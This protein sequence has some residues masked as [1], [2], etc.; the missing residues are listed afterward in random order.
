MVSVYCHN[1]THI[2]VLWNGRIGLQEHAAEAYV[3]ADGSKLGNGVSE[4][5]FYV[6]RIA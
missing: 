3:F 2:A 6:E 4:I 1:E 5:K